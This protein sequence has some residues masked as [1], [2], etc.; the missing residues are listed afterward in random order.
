MEWFIWMFQNRSK[1]L[2]KVHVVIGHKSCDLD[3]LISAFTYAYFLDKVREKI[4]HFTFELWC[5]LKNQHFWKNKEPTNLIFHVL[6]F[7]CRD[8]I[9]SI[10][11][12]ICIGHF[13]HVS[14]FLPTLCIK[15]YF[16]KINFF[17][18]K[19]ITI[20]Y[21]SWL[22]LWKFRELIKVRVR[23]SCFPLS[24]LLDNLALGSRKIGAE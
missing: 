8:L 16:N 14:Y 2:E 19:T 20:F 12:Q 22:L 11:Q 7:C 24:S 17:S 3:S 5:N 10:N 4:M 1:R 21:N 13:L 9:E 6:V 23:I 18:K 15:H